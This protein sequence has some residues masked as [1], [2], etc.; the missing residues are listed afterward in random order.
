MVIQTLAPLQLSLNLW[1]LQNIHYTVGK[2]ILVDKERITGQ[3]GQK[4]KLWQEAYNALG[5]ILGIH[6]N[7]GSSD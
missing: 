1:L 6:V 2:E 7:A 3:D 4:R 5:D